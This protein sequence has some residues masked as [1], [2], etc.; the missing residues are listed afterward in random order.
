MAGGADMVSIPVRTWRAS[1]VAMALLLGAQ[2][3]P[4]F[5]AAVRADAREHRV[6]G[7]AHVV[8]RIVADGLEKYQFSGA[9][10][11]VPVWLQFAGPRIQGRAAS[12]IEAL[13]EAEDHY[14]K[15][16]GYH[17]VDTQKLTPATSVAYL[18]LNYERGPLY[19][20][21]RVYEYKNTQYV[22]EFATALGPEAVFP[23]RLQ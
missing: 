2:M 1:I 21:F 3:L 11:A 9:A 23:E 16:V 17:V 15:F 4:M 7:T 14:G 18:V 22:T 6:T 8:P 19:A 12:Y 20:R 10:V 5:S 13:R